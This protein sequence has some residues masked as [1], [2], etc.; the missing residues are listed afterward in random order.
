MVELARFVVLVLVLITHSESVL[1]V[2]QS[3]IND[4]WGLAGGIVEYGQ[5]IDD[6]AVTYVKDQTGL[7][8]EL[9]RILAIY[10]SEYDETLTIVFEAAATRADQHIDEDHQGI[11]RYYGFEELPVLEGDHGDYLGTLLGN[12]GGILIEARR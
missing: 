12:T 6:V 7:D 11:A 1:L 9:S 5:K 2:K 10:T 3:H 4:T 8:A